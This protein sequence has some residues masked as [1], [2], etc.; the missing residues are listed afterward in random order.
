MIAVQRTVDGAC[1]LVKRPRGRMD[2]LRIKDNEREELIRLL[3][4]TLT[5]DLEPGSIV[6]EVQ[7]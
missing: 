1:I 2:I 6:R 3:L 4:Q 7:N 5:P